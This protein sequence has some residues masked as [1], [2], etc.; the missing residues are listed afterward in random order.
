MVSSVTDRAEPN[1]SKCPRQTGMQWMVRSAV[2]GRGGAFRS[3]DENPWARKAAVREEVLGGALKHAARSTFKFEPTVL[4]GSGPGARCD[5]LDEVVDGLRWM[6]LFGEDGRDD[7][8]AF[9][10]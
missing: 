8:G 3:H 7:L 6:A 4:L 5:A 10:F 2:G 1:I 9:G